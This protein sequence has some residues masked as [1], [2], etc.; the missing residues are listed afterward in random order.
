MTRKPMFPRT[1]AR[2]A[3]LVAADALSRRRNAGLELL[4]LAAEPQRLGVV[5]EDRLVEHGEV[6]AR[7][8]IVRI[9]G[10]RLLEPLPRLV[11][12]ARPAGQPTEGVERLGRIRV[13]GERFAQRLMRLFVTRDLAEADGKV[14]AGAVVVGP[15]RHRGAV[16]RARG[17]SNA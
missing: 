7:G 11:R 5:P 14:D 12:L 3:G 2:R 8:D 4:H 9:E 10:E 1:L 17:V 13:H 15:P 16:S 6:H